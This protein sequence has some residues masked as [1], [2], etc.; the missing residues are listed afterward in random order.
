L[1]PRTC[2][3]YRRCVPHR[4]WI[5]NLFQFLLEIF[6]SHNKFWGYVPPVPTYW[7]P[8]IYKC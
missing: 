4:I 2:P 8:V 5:Y 6:G 7:A 3:G 1:P